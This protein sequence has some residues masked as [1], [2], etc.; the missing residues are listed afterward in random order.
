MGI[1]IRDRCRARWAS[2]GRDGVAGFGAYFLDH[3]VESPRLSWVNGEEVPSGSWASL[4]AGRSTD[5]A[6]ELVHRGARVVVV[7]GTA[8]RLVDGSHRPRD[9]DVAVLEQE[10]PTLVS[11]L[12]Q[13]GVRVSAATLLRCRQVGLTSAWGPIDIFVREALPPAGVMQVGGCALAVAHD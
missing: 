6:I 1:R 13:I 10:V 11:A 7:G 4:V 8:R 9:L 2:P 3:R 12:A 5:L